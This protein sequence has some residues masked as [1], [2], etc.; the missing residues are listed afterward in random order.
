MRSVGIALARKALGIRVDT[1]L[2]LLDEGRRGLF[3]AEALL[4][5][6]GAK[7]AC[8]A[9]HAYGQSMRAARFAVF[10]ALQKEYARLRG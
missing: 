7:D 1:P 3:R 8:A 10:E 4:M 2:E 5:I 6:M 9:I